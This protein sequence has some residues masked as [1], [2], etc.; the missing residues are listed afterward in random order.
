MVVSGW[1]LRQHILRAGLFAL[2]WWVLTDG[3]AASW[4][5]GVPMVALATL[6]SLVL[7]PP[8]SRSWRLWGVVLY[9][10]FFAWYSLRGGIDVALRALSPR[11][12]LDPALITYPLRLRDDAAQVILINTISLLPGTLS[13]E[14][15]ENS[16]RVHVLANE[17]QVERSLERIEQIVALLFG[18]EL[19]PALGESEVLHV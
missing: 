14:L 15:H 1:W 2:L 19:A 3:A 5:F 7:L 4:W 13:A 17:P 12:P 6:V 18:I 9:A 11:L 10:G 8:T 16:L